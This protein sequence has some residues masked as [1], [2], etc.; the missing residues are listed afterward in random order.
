[1]DPL[2]P[3][4]KTEIIED[5]AMKVVSRSGALGGRLH[6]LTLQAVID[7]LRIINSYYSNLIEGHSTHPIDIERAMREDYSTDPGKRDLQH[8]SLAH[9]KCQRRIEERLLSEP[10]LN[11]ADPN[12]ITWVHEIFYEQLPR[13]LRQVK[14]PQTGEKLEVIPGEVRKRE[15]EVGHHVGPD[16]NALS[17]FLERFCEAYTPSKFHGHT[18]LIAIAA[19]HH[20]LMWIHPFLDGNGR[21]TRLF[22]DAFF[23]RIPALSGYGIWNVSRGLARNRDEYMAHLSLADTTRR[24][25][26]D[27]RGNLSNEGL[28]KFCFFFLKTCL[29]QID[30]MNN[31]LGLDNLLAR[32]DGYIKMRVAG[33]LPGKPDSPQLKLEASFMLQETLLRGHVPRGDLARYSG[34]KERSAR[35]LLGNLLEEG[36]LVSD[37]PKGPVKMGFPAHAAS[38]LFPDLYPVQIGR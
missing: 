1:M 12:F 2:F 16:S 8:E 38:Y 19:S 36:L 37:T 24:N 23:Q 20:R 21:V 30:Y 6:P 4:G 15:V 29:D 22:T 13:E 14:N 34:M 32:I 7:L 10:D 9:I 33:V 11:I 25:D 28:L 26:L 31:L 3:A 35:D 27:G 5:L 18:P 17:R